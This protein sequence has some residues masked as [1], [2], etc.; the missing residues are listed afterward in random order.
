[1]NQEMQPQMNRK[2]ERK[3]NSRKR[4]SIHANYSPLRKCYFV[5]EGVEVDFLTQSVSPQLNLEDDEILSILSGSPSFEK[6]P[7]GETSIYNE[8]DEIVV[9]INHKYIQRSKSSLS[10]DFERSKTPEIFE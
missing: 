2:C 5:E 1:M 7:Y 4:K 6:E 8:D 9:N 10:F 3:Y